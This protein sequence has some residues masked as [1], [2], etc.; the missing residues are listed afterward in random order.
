MMRRPT[1]V[2]L[3]V[4][5]SVLLVAESGAR[6]LATRLPGPVYWDTPFSQ[7]KAGQIEE[8]G[9]VDIVFMGS[10]IANAGIDPPLVV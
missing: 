9:A 8:T 1:V 6:L 7:D 2:A 10:S 5:L 4:A 3:V